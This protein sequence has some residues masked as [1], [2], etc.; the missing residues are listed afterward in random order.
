MRTY[1]FVLTV[2]LSLGGPRWMQSLSPATT[3]Q[4]AIVD[5]TQK[6][7]PRTLD[8]DQGNRESLLDE[9]GDY[10]PDGWRKFIK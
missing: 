3:D 10:T 9:Q 7:V 5:F 4:A 8:Y 6:A 2:G 1:S